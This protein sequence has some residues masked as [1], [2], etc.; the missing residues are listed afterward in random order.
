MLL[1]LSMI[2]AVLPLLGL[3]MTLLAFL[4]DLR[5]RASRTSGDSMP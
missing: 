4:V 3:A 1:L 2:L 5:S